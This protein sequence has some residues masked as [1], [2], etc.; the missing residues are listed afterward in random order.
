MGRVN[1]FHIQFSAA[2]II[3]ERWGLY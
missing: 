2:V 1:D 3:N